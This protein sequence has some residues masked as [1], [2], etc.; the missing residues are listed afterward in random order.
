MIKDNLY[1]LN[2][3]MSTI[4]KTIPKEIW[5]TK[6]RI[7]WN[8]L[9]YIKLELS[10]DDIDVKIQYIDLDSYLSAI[11]NVFGFTIDILVDGEKKIKGNLWNNLISNYICDVEST[12][13][14]GNKLITQD[15][16]EDYIGNYLLEVKRDRIKDCEEIANMHSILK[17]VQLHDNKVL[18]YYIYGNENKRNIILLN[19][20][21]ID[22]KIW[23]LIINKLQKKFR[24]IVWDLTTLEEAFSIAET[25]YLEALDRVMN[26]ER[27]KS[28]DLI[29]W[30][31]GSKTLIEYYRDNADKVN[32]IT[33]VNPYLT[34]IGNED[35]MTDFDRNIGSLSQLIWKKEELAYSPLVNQFIS[36]LFKADLKARMKIEHDACDSKEYL[37]NILGASI[38]EEV[39]DIITRPFMKGRSLVNYSKITVE[40]QKHNVFQ[41]LPYIKC[42]VMVINAGLDIVTNELAVELSK[43]FISQCNYVYLNSAT[44]WCIWDNYDYVNTLVAQ[45]LQCI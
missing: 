23:K 4:L 42:P 29:S 16:F 12:R 33:F 6:V 20:Y 36:K 10:Y 8:G 21:G 1:W 31:S 44:H 17:Q 26:Q 3:L 37:K 25:D 11:E 2:Y 13:E 35:Y 39:K 5:N 45:F 43:D 28:V 19:A 24:I 40:L 30:C 14:C 15:Q 32:T 27:I 7:H 18:D 38:T 34:P 41:F 9:P 22:F